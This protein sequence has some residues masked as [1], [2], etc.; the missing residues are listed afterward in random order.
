[1]SLLKRRTVDTGP[2][3]RLL[4][5][6]I[7]SDSFCRDMLPLIGKE[8]IET[9]YISRVVGWCR[10][11]YATYKQS[12]G[13]HIKDLYEVE[14][15]KLELPDQQAISTILTKLSE[16][17]STSEINEDFIRDESLKLIDLR[18]LKY[19]AEQI[20][21]LVELGRLD[22]A[23]KIAKSYRE[24]NIE[25]SGW[26]DPFDSSTIKNHFVD[27]ESRK[28]FVFKFPGALGDFIGPIERNWLVGMMGPPKRGKTFWLIES[29]IQA[30]LS[31][32]KSIFISLEMDK[33]RVRRR[34]YS[35]LTVMAS[36]TKDYVYPVFDCFKNQ[37]NSCN[38][39]E[40]TNNTR[41]LD[42][43]DKKP[44]EFNPSL[45]YRCCTACRGKIDF[46][47]TTW[48]TSTQVERMKNMEA[49]KLL[50]AQ[51][52]HFGFDKEYGSNLRLLAYPAFS[53]NI[54]R[55]R[56]DI[57]N[58]IDVK[59]FITDHI[60]LDYA[61][62]LA[63]EDARVTGRDRIDET[64][65]TLKRMSDELHCSIFTGSQ[66]NRGSIDKKNVVQQDA[67]EDIRKIA[68][69]DLFLAINQTPQEKKSKITRI[70]KIA[71]RDGVFDQ[72]ESVIVLQQL[73]L[74][75]ICLDSYM[76][77][78]TVVRENIFEDYFD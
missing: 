54:S 10:D 17:Y 39:R 20:N 18:S 2:E 55:M 34:I 73:D 35:R 12:P 40:R 58:L 61:D 64:W 25:T 27:E 43:E 59:G 8:T 5:G 77:R 7:V 31:K 60:A 67:A 78:P 26:E 46:Q 11:Y 62:I 71:K 32:K 69:S 68:N 63:P 47:P 45:R 37:N 15:D 52:E 50:I 66:S 72:Y 75:Q 4:T 3:E 29:C 57:Q 33:Q 36:E 38:K 1:M 6:L 28:S 24:K 23:K 49:M 42:S 41:L 19:S 21:S 30:L 22:E 48:F 16:E 56:G 14:K 13:I 44:L 76:D 74:G 65:K 51:A 9:P 70:S 53:A